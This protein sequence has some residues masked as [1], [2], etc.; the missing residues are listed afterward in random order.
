MR[1]YL[2]GTG[3][4]TA[5]TGGLT[6]LRSLRSNEP[7]TW[8]TALALLSWGIPLALAIGSVVATRRATR[9]GIVP[10]ASPVA[11]TETKLLRQRPR[12]RRVHAIA[13]TPTTTRNAFG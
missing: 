7:F 13:T 6:L 11:G 2:F 5:I 4:L 3:L 12:R 10:S 1:K 9:V 8:R